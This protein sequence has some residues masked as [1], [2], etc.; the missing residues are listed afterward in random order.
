M[1]TTQCLLKYRVIF[2]TGTP[3]KVLSV[4]LHSKSHQKSSKCQNLL[5]EKNLWFLGGH[6]LKNHPVYGTSHQAAAWPACL[7][8]WSATWQATHTCHHQKDPSGDTLVWVS[9][10]F[11][12]SILSCIRASSEPTKTTGASTRRPSQKTSSLSWPTFL[13]LPATTLDISNPSY[14]AWYI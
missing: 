1:H 4:G 7:S 9:W 10:L 3:L 13:F 8:W 14:Y 12:S 5:T 2:F 6:Q 11:C